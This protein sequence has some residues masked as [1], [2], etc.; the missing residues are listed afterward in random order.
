M[1]RKPEPVVGGFATMGPGH[2][3]DEQPMPLRWGAP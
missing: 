3:L 1:D 2:Y